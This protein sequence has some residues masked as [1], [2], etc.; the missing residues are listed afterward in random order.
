MLNNDT[1]RL[2]FRKN[3]A[4]DMPD[5]CFLPEWLCQCMAENIENLCSQLHFYP[6]KTFSDSRYFLE[7][8]WGYLD[9]KIQEYINNHQKIAII[10]APPYGYIDPNFIEFIKAYK[11]KL[12][13]HLDLSQGY[14]L[15]DFS[16]MISL[17]DYTYFSFNGRKLINDG[18]ALVLSNSQEFEQMYQLFS[19]RALVE[20]SNFDLLKNDI[21]DRFNIKEFFGDNTRSNYLRTVVASSIHDQ[22]LEKE[23][24]GQPLLKNPNKKYILHSNNYETWLSNCFLIFDQRRH[25]Q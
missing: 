21:W 18:G 7:I 9:K 11:S 25:V 3:V 20:I 13:L 12:T 17:C 10:I 5:V 4:N 19:Q 2:L 14:G 22:F 15:F 8:D 1:V 23:G 24:Y 16:E 6:V